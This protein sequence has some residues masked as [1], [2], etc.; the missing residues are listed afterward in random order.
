MRW[1]LLNALGFCAG[2]VGIY[3]ASAGRYDEALMLLVMELGTAWFIWCDIRIDKKHEED[4]RL[5]AIESREW[6]SYLP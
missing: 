5:A 6:D 1:A 3:L 2:G 4:A